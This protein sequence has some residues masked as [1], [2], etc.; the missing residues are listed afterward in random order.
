M[1][2]YAM[3]RCQPEQDVSRD[4]ADN[5]HGCCASAFLCGHESDSNVVSSEYSIIDSSESTFSR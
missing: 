5:G 4:E 2:W 3:H 1:I